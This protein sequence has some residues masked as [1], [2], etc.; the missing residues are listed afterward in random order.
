M[1]YNPEVVRVN[2]RSLL[3]RHVFHLTALNLVKI[4]WVLETKRIRNAV[5]KGKERADIYRLG[6]LGIVPTT[7]AEFLRVVRCQSVRRLGEF[8]DVPQE[9]VLLLPEARGLQITLHQ[10]FVDLLV[11]SLQLQEERVRTRSVR[12]AIQPRD[13]GR[14]HLF[15][16]SGKMP[17]FKMKGIDKL[18]ELL[19]HVGALTEALQNAR[20]IATIVT[21]FPTSVNLRELTFRVSVLK[22]LNMWHVGLTFTVGLGKLKPE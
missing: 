1:R 17:F 14:D 20:D 3:P 4:V 6:D 22:P 13:I 19:E 2:Q 9:L 10:C 11:S 8:L 21:G 5:E 15:Q 16:P 18:D 7:L 12:T